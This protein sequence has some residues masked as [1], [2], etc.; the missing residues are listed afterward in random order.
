MKDCLVVVSKVKKLVTSAGGARVSGEF[1]EALSALVEE[2]VRE[3]L[4]RAVDAKRVT[5]KACDLKGT[6]DD[7]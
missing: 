2:A 6:A 7:T 3:A 5:L 4:P 1:L